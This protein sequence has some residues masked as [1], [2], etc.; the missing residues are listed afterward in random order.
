VKI[1]LITLILSY[2]VSI[3]FDAA[4]RNTTT[5]T[6]IFQVP[7]PFLTK[8]SCLS[9]PL[10]YFKGLRRAEFSS[11]HRW[12]PGRRGVRPRLRP[13]V[14]GPNDRCGVP[15]SG[16]DSGVGLI[17]EYIQLFSSAH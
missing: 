4:L 6:L 3:V 15:A 5:Q 1:H 13:P 17:H 7:V 11:Q 16:T 10:L 8:F 14:C 2:Y 12:L 9:P